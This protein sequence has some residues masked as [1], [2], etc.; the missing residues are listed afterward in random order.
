MIKFL[1]SATNSNNWPLNTGKEILLVGRSNVGKST[2][3]NRIA[4]QKI[5][6]VGKTPGKT[7]LL[8]FYEFEKYYLVDAPGYGY[9]KRNECEKEQY[10]LMMEEYLSERKN[11]SLVIMLLDARRIPSSED[12][13]M[14]TY[15]TYYHLPTFLVATK[16]DKLK[17]CQ[18][19]ANLKIITQSLNL[20][21]N[22]IWFKD[23]SKQNEANELNDYLIELLTNKS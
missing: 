13:E 12:K 19:K 16:I 17:N 23:L 4:K 10:R 6:Y 3:I 20:P 22:A 14:L 18:I 15:L 21:I 7:R 9:A 1:T 11:L 2:F 8:N 5:A